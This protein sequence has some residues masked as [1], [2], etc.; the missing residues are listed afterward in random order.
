MSEEKTS[1]KPE[2]LITFD[3]F[4]EM[5]E[6]AGISTSNVAHLE[7]DYRLGKAL[8]EVTDAIIDIN[9]KPAEWQPL[10]RLGNLMDH[11]LEAVDTGKD[12]RGIALDLATAAIRYAAELESPKKSE[13]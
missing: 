4:V 9:E 10:G 2:D 7:S 3:E 8:A 6:Q 12:Q 5:C 11:L 13:N 1:E